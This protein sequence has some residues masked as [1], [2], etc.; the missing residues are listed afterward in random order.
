MNSKFVQR[1]LEYKK[2]LIETLKQNKE[3]ILS[4]GLPLLKACVKFLK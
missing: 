1:S 3:K 4:Y 2:N